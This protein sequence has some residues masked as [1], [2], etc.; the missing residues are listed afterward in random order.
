VRD[1]L[2]T[3][4]EKE[5]KLSPPKRVIPIRPSTYQGALARNNNARCKGQDTQE[6]EE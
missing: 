3:W 5:R 2:E 1:R 6:N 4:N